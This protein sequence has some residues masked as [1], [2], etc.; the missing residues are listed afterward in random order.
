MNTA[1]LFEILKKRRFPVTDLAKETEIDYA[2]MAKWVPK[3]DKKYSRP[4][5]DDQKLLE[6]CINVI[7][8]L[9]NLKQKKDFQTINVDGFAKYVEQN[10]PQ[11][12]DMIGT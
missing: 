8:A 11:L 5:G 3:P 10:L 1:L 4:K 2:R 9:L 6:K 7:F 12:M